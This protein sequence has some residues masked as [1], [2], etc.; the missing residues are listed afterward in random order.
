MHSPPIRNHV[1][2][3]TL[4]LSPPLHPPI[5]KLCRLPSQYPPSFSFQI[6]FQPP[7]LRVDRGGLSNRCG[8]PS[9]A[10]GPSSHQ[11]R[12]GKQSEAQSSGSQV[13]AEKLQNKNSR[14]GW[15]APR[16]AM[17]TQRRKLFAT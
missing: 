17:R 12:G 10:R 11:R 14:R 13:G 7:L 15:R 16:Q 5:S 9:Q 6:Y 1:T 3:K 2:R 8:G 4:N